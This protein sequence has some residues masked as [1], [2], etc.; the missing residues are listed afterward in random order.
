MP[1]SSSW[2]GTYYAKFRDNLIIRSTRTATPP[3]NSS[4]RHHHVAESAFIVRVPEAEAHVGD[5][6]ER[7]DP[8][9]QS[10]VPA[11]I[12]ILVPFMSPERLTDAVL[13]RAHRALSDVASFSFSLAEVRRFPGTA[14]L[15][16]EPAEPFIALTESLVRA[17]P[18]YPPF[19][20][21]FDSVVP[22]LTVAHGD[23]TR[24]KAAER[25]LSNIMRVRGPVASTC[26]EVA[27][28][29]NSTG[30]WRAM[31]HFALPAGRDRA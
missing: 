29:E 15:A 10:G 22:H 5:L 31:H 7:F 4:V 21:E 2:L 14:Y 8:S 30:M 3:L 9:F 17:F 28:I 23:A 13:Q 20:G 1:S 25:E 11:H 6:R 18:Q 24:A 12:T 26:T 16:P 19:G 27:L